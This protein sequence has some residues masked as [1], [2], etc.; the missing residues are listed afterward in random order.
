MNINKTNWLRI[1]RNFYETEDY[2]IVQKLKHKDY[3]EEAQKLIELATNEF[4]EPLD[5]TIPKEF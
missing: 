3:S 1:M 4:K 2:H 5:C